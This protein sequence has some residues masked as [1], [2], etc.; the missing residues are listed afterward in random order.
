MQL[1]DVIDDDPESD[2]TAGFI[3]SI[4]G[5]FRP[6]NGRKIQI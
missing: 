4:L 2:G 3:A 5:D 6:E 1:D